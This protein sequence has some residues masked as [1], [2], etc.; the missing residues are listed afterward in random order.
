V[1]KSRTGVPVARASITYTSETLA[2]TGILKTDEAGYYFLPS[3]SAGTYRVRCE[4]AGYQ[5]QQLELPVAGRIG[6]RSGA[7]LGGFVL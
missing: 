7:S 5:S 3:P 1:I 2:A 6:A 4:A